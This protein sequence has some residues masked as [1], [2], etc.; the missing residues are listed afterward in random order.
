MNVRI[1][2]QVGGLRNA[3]RKK[4]ASASS[5]SSEV[6]GS[7]TWQRCSFHASGRDVFTSSLRVRLG[8][9]LSLSGLVCAA[10]VERTIRCQTWSASGPEMRMTAT[11]DFAGGVERA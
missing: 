10:R 7:M 11:P 9:G 5:R 6:C 1:S 3:P 4:T 8:V 2:R